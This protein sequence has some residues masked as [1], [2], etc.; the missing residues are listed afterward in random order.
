MAQHI[1]YPPRQLAVVPSKAGTLRIVN[2]T[3]P[4]RPYRTVKHAARVYYWFEFEGAHWTGWH[5]PILNVFT[6]RQ[7]QAPAFA[8]APATPPAAS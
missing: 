7:I 5:G 2:Q 4:V 8:N 6:A 3:E 1:P